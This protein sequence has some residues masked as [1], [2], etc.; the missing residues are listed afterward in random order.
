MLLISG[1][2]QDYE[3]ASLIYYSLHLD[4]ALLRMSPS[5]LRFLF[6]CSQ[7]T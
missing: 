4:A 2:D 3:C 6:Y 5:Y 1:L 7:L